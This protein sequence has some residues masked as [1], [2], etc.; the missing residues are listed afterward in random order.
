ML[1]IVRGIIW[2]GLYLFLI[3]LPLA[4]AILADPARI[5]QPFLIELGVA[6]GFIG[7]SIMALEFAL[8]S[9][10]EPANEPFGEDS[11]QLF[12]NIMGTVALAFVLA[13]PILLILAGYPADCWLNPFSSCATTTTIMADV[14]VF[15]LLLLIASSIWRKR[16]GIKYEVWYGLHGLFSLVVIATALVH[17]FIIGRYTS[18]YIMQATWLLYAALLLG[19]IVWY[20]IWTPLRNWN[21][22][23]EVV[24]NRVERGDSRTLVLKPDNHDGFHFHPGQFAWIKSGR[25]PFGMGQHPI[26]LSSQGEVEPGGTVAFTIKNLGDWSGE[27]VP[28]LK[29]GDRVWLDGPHGVFTM[30]REQAMGYVFI[31]GGIG[32]TPL[33]SMLQTMVKRE[34]ERPVVLFYGAAN[35][36]EMTF[37]E[38]LLALEEKMNL[39]VV[40]VYSEPEEGWQGETGYITGEIMKKYLPK[41][42]KYFK[43]LICGP[44]P[45]M[46]AMEEALPELGVPELSVLSERFDMV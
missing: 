1:L 17:I 43:Y 40:P 5:E 6:V 10:I 44:E 28:A 29:P 35:S 45:L 30:D 12:H 37:R 32:I 19:L 46:D 2:Y 39:K 36:E 9:R 23:W 15:I 26:S 27:E 7:F 4:V 24:E 33:Y 13:H 20:K 21:H 3:L 11:L 16:L 41:Q 18:T 14:A 38:E 25:T 8:I 34:D 31:G 42:Y 22:K